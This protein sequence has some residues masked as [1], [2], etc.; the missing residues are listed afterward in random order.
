M[1]FDDHYDNL[2]FPC[3]VRSHSPGTMMI[4]NS[5]A[6]SIRISIRMV[7]IA[8]PKLQRV[9]QIPDILGRQVIIAPGAPYSSLVALGSLVYK[10]R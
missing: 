9:L 7:E 6:E 5:K 3:M 4:L 8:V 2:I 1:I 10:V